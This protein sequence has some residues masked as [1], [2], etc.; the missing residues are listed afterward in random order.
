MPLFLEPL[1]FDVR[2]SKDTNAADELIQ[3]YPAARPEAWSVPSKVTEQDLEKPRI[4][5]QQPWRMMIKQT[6]WIRY[7]RK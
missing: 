6:G 7:S 2:H 3:A 1:Q 5:H 4:R